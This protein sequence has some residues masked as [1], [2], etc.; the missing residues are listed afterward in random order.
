MKH[1]ETPEDE[2]QKINRACTAFVGQLKSM[3]V[4][5]GVAVG[6]LS[7]SLFDLSE[8]GTLAYVSF[9]SGEVR[10]VWV[11]RDGNDRPIDPEFRLRG[12][13]TNLALSPDGSRLAYSS[14]SD[15]VVDIWVKEL[16]RGPSSRLTRGEGTQSFRPSWSSGESVTYVSN[17]S[18]QRDVWTSRAQISRRQ[19]AVCRFVRS[20]GN[21]KLL[22]IVGAMRAPCCL[23][24][25]ADCRQERRNQDAD[26]GNDY[27]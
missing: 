4:L 5:E 25:R 15:G 16:D 24:R 2:D 7:A 14:Y 20:C 18:G 21:A 19:T 23:S 22:E 12:G 1:P 3:I 27:K 8:T 26:D 10:P 11:D 17:R 9:E 13:F 6:A